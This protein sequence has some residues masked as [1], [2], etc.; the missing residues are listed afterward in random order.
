MDINYNKM[1]INHY[2]NNKIKTEECKYF[3]I[4]IYSILL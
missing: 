1:F 3:C 4:L 2:Q